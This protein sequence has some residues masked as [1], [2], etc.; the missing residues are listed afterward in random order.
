VLLVLGSPA[1]EAGQ[2]EPPAAGVGA[3]AG[4]TY[5]TET[6][7]GRHQTGLHLEGTVEIGARP[8]WVVTAGLFGL[9]DDAPSVSDLTSDGTVVRRPDVFRTVTLTVGPQVPIGRS[10][11]VR[12]S[13]GI[14]RHRFAVYEFGEAGPVAAGTSAETGLAYG[15]AAGRRFPVTRR[16]AVRIEGFVLWSAGEDSSGA[17]RLVGVSVVPMVRLRDGR[18][19]SRG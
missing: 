11:Y 12:P 16:A 7:A 2:R 13:A 8:R 15:V 4:L 3:G 9:R 14:G 10:L 17:R 18:R 6:E 1:A 5:L 19:W